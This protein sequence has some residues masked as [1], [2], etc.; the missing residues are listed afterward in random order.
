MVKNPWARQGWKGRF[1]PTDAQNWTPQ[2]RKALGYD[3]KKHIKKDDGIFWIEYNDL[4]QWY[5]SLYINWNPNLFKYSI[6]QHGFW[7]VNV[8]PKNDSINIGYNPQ[9]TLDIQIGNDNNNDNESNV[10]DGGS[11]WILLSKH[12]KNTKREEQS[13]EDFLSLRVYDESTTMKNIDRRVFYRKNALHTGV[14]IDSPHYLMKMDVNTGDNNIKKS[15]KYQRH[16]TVVISQ[17]EKKNDVSYTI[18]AYSTLPCRFKPILDKK[19]WKY[20]KV[21]VGQWT[22]KYCGGSVTKDSYLDNPQFLIQLS[23]KA[24]IRIL[25]EAPIEFSVN[26]LVFKCI[27]LNDDGTPINNDNNDNNTSNDT[28]NNNENETK[29]ASDNST[30]NGRLTKREHYAKKLIVGDSG[31]YRPG[32]SYVDIPK[33]GEGIYVAVISTFETNKIGRFKIT[34]KSTENMKFKPI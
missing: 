2:L 20:S 11:V 15:K 10:V 8:G 28:D 27:T 33:I 4:K 7:S 17:Y 14:Y 24:N 5:S 13:K 30:N 16:Y 25:L 12:M 31:S 3:P 32:V 9:Y 29:D 34:I 23:W 6:S 1:S 22:K 26:I 19:F 21:L 18:I